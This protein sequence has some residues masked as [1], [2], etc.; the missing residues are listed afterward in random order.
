MGHPG[1]GPGDLCAALVPAG[2]TFPAQPPPMVDRLARPDSGSNSQ[3][4]TYTGI[5]HQRHAPPYV[6]LAT[7]TL[8]GIADFYFCTENEIFRRYRCHRNGAV[9]A[10]Q[11]RH[12]KFAKF[13]K[14]KV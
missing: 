1:H 3:C 4:T 8:G 7:R 11:K 9:L 12:L 6:L 14:N 2:V 13:E 5:S 10:G